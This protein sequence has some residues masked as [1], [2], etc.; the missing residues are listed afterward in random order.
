MRSG[1]DTK[2][3]IAYS[4]TSGA[5]ASTGP[6]PLRAAPCLEA[7]VGKLDAAP[8]QIET[9]PRAPGHRPGQSR[10]PGATRTELATEREMVV[11]QR[12]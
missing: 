11:L 2:P 7:A 9:A 5:V 8:A 1:N 3:L 12:R 4:R 6:E 10:R